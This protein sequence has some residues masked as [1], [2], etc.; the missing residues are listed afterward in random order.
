[1]EQRIRS[2]L[3]RLRGPQQQ[4]GIVP[5]SSVNGPATGKVGRVASSHPRQSRQNGLWNRLEIPL[6]II[7]A[8]RRV[9][10]RIARSIYDNNADK[11][12][13]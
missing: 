10:S 12:T 13:H 9:F 5:T 3:G 8:E 4:R 2:F 11:T 7:P 1:M 6:P